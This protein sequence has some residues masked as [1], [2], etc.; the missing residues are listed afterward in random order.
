MKNSIENAI[1]TLEKRI[2]GNK[3]RIL[4]NDLNTI[5]SYHEGRIHAY[6]D[7]IKI[8]KLEVK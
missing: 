7:A 3:E 4:V 5:I 1:E 2:K 6:E 8:I